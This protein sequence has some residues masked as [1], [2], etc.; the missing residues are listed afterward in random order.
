VRRRDVAIVLG[1]LGLAGF[2]AADAIRSDGE[3]RAEATAPTETT[4][5]DTGSTS[6]LADTEGF[7][8]GALRGSLV[9]T[10]ADDCRVREI[11]LAGA[12]ERPLPRLAGDC[13]LW[14]PPLGP[15]IAWGLSDAGDDAVPFTFFDLNDPNLDFGGYG[16][17][18]GFITWSPDGRRAAWCT[19][20]R[21]GIDYRLNGPLRRLPDCPAVYLDDETVAYAQGDALVDERGRVVLRTHG[22]ITHAAL[23][24][25]GSFGLTV[26]GRRLERWQGGR[27][28]HAAAIPPHLRGS[29]PVLAPDNCAAI[30]RGGGLE[31]V[32]LAC[33]PPS[34]DTD[35]LIFVGIAADWSPDGQWIAIAE[36]RNSVEITFVRVVGP[37]ERV[38]YPAG[39][40]AVHWRS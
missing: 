13:S 27:R 6:T 9:F 18:F 32:K 25:D 5:P 8:T 7:R 29:L 20:Q 35:P 15:H 39:A 10:D 28:T 11:G 3:Q 22:T 38:S 30:F 31:V 12:N 26:D 23:G 1:V 17:L 40:A 37:Q 33:F 19:K 14:G 34:D 36:G 21:V 4:A 2:A 16:A 24:A